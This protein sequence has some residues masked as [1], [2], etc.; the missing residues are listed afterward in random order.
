MIYQLKAVE[1]YGGNAKN[2]DILFK[3]VYIHEVKERHVR[4]AEAVDSNSL[5]Y[6]NIKSKKYPRF[7]TWILGILDL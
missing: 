4:F 2:M 1:R 6:Y 5:N 7:Q 3:Q